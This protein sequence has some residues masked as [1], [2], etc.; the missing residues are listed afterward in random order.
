MVTASIYVLY[1]HI[2]YCGAPIYISIQYNN[3]PTY[4]RT[5]EI[6]DFLDSV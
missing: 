6:Y 3:M 1:I 2:I 4:R 5:D